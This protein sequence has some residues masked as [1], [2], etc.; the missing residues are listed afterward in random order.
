MSISW[1]VPQYD[2]P[3][4]AAS[5]LIAIYASFVALDLAKRV[6]SSDRA[7][8]RAWL[9]GGSLMMGTGIWS[10][11]FLGMLAF[12]LPVAVGY[13]YGLTALS[14][15]AAVA[16]SGVALGMT[17][18]STSL[19]PG[20]L[21]AGAALMGGGICTMHYT[22]MAAMRMSPPI[23]WDWAWVAASAGIAVGVSAVALAIF[24]WL[25]ERIGWAAGMWQA[26][27]AIV[28]GLAIAGMHYTGMAA[29]N[30]AEGSVCLS[31]GGLSGKVLGEL[32]GAATVVLLTMTLVT[33]VM[34]G[35][36][37]SKATRLADSLQ[38]ANAELQHLAFHD[39]LTGLRNR[40]MFED[41]L[42][43]AAAYCDRQ[44]E[45]VAVFFIDLDGFKPIND[46]W[47]HNA[48]DALLREVA[49]R[50]EA[51]GRE[52]DVVARVGGD[53]FVMLMAPMPDTGAA[54]QLAQRLIDLVGR[55]MCLAGRDHTVS[56][57]IGIAVYPSD[58]PRDKLI[59]NADAAMY[60]AKR[61]GGTCFR[62]F[63]ARMDAGARELVELAR[64]LRVA[65]DGNQLLLHYQPK[66][67]GG[68]GQITGVEAL[69]RW[70]HPT[71]GLVGPAAF[72]PVAE[73][74]GLIGALGQ[75]VLE[76]CCRQLQAWTEEGLRMRAAIN[77]SVLQLR[78]DDLADRVQAA[79]ERYLVEPSQLTFELTESAAMDDPEMT[80]CTFQ[81]LAS[82]GIT[83][84]ID[85]FGTGY[86]SLS[87]LRRLPT[88]QLKIDRCFVQDLESSADARSIVDA[89]VRL[90]HALGRK[91]VAEGVETDAQHQI[92]RDFGCDELQGFLFA[93]PMAAASLQQW[94]ME[95]DPSRPG[96]RP[97]LFDDRSLGAA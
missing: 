96:F 87:Y 88:Q 45:S 32:I 1:V 22:G 63:E 27:A 29:A 41:R 80:L 40:L 49:G 13:E 58:G 26:A 15:L 17:A 62:F 9:L 54:A 4:V 97:S 33:S 56:C 89:V 66:I 86:S 37:Q 60:T 47:G 91:V 3:T 51:A 34:D 25:R 57:S 72:I 85:D 14:W 39:P 75:W 31:S 76:E 28:M 61:A 52:S 11:H 67:H 5:V 77:L 83:L 43:Q 24:H 23:V 19:T 93:K 69:V 68:S 21:V 59:A 84:S 36:L 20:R 78:Q 79:M 71:R 42:S 94:A 90:A 73:R 82:I 38:K 92:L 70:N 12:Q 95:K 74:S 81:R 6:R 64:E 7:L 53:E 8:A 46:S 10:M 18:S 55:P 65:I 44:G 50:I 48:G 2:A 16:V 35:R 30:F